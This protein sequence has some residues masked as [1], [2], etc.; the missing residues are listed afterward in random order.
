MKNEL[1]KVKHLWTVICRSSS[2]DSITKNFSLS[3][4]LDEVQVGKK[5]ASG[6]SLLP[7]KGESIPLDFQVV[8]LWKKMDGEKNEKIALE[9]ELQVVD[10]EGETL[11][12]QPFPI[13]INEGK[14]RTRAIIGFPA[15]K[16]TGPGEYTFKIKARE[17]KKGSFVEADEA[18][19]NVRFA[20]K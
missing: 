4:V 3:N 15:F 1:K 12:T 11:L 19:F 6:K 16:V 14:Q 8:T 17:D 5:D 7:A 2:I 18:Y 20:L 13:V 10:P 9:G